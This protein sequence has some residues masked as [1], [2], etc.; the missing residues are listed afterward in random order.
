VVIGISDQFK[1][2]VRYIGLGEK[3]ED[4]QLFNRQAFVSSLFEQ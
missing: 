2:P 3:M 4:L 1:I